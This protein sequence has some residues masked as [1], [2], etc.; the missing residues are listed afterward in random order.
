LNNNP[1]QKIIFE[2]LFVIMKLKFLE[3]LND[4]N[5]SVVKL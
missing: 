4:D 2:F 3:E 5:V 1:S